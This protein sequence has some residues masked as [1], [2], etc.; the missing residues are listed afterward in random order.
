MAKGVCQDS[1][2]MKDYLIY[3]PNSGDYPF[4]EK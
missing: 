2:K 4:K 3:N 1:G